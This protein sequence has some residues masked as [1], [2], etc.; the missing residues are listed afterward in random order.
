MRKQTLKL[1][2]F[3]VMGVLV[4]VPGLLAQNPATTIAT[5]SRPIDFQWAGDQ[6][7]AAIF[8]SAQG[9]TIPMSTFSRK[10][11]KDG[12][13]YTSTIVGSSPFAATLTGTSINAVVIPVVFVLGSNTFDPT[14]SD[15]CDG[16]V[17]AL[18]RFK[19]SPLSQNVPNLKING[20][21]VGNTQ[22]INGFRRAE[23]WSLIGG[24][25]GAAYQNTI[26][27][28][29]ASPYT[30]APSAYGISGDPATCSQFGAVRNNWL[31]T[32]LASTVIPQ[33]QAQGVIS[34]TSFAIFLFRNVVQLDSNDQCCILG[35]HSWT[36]S[37]IQTYATAN[38]DT[39]KPGVFVGVADGSVASHEIAEWM[40]DPLTN[41]ATPAWGKLGQVAN[42]QTNWESGDP[43]SGKLMAPITLNGYAYH[44]QEL[45]YFSFFFNSPSDPSFGASYY[46]YLGATFSSYGTILGAA[47]ACPAPG[48][49]TP[50]QYE[51]GIGPPPP[52]STL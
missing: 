10:A 6:N 44:M 24:P 39:T 13:T 5:P 28:T 2:A 49:W 12:K 7:A 47:S 29:Y 42:C 38:W 36:G 18:T 3:A 34:P 25:K 50:F 27:F 33:L 11:S 17:S 35:Y 37:P 48:G 23:F 43:L 30:I 1:G 51:Y 52:P 20:V 22:F 19:Q 41:N 16:G 9:T 15:V 46:R 8:Q 32:Y 14:A 40:D 26:N 21:N 4:T 45:A 31:N